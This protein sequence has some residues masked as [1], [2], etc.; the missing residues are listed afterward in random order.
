MD[1]LINLIVRFSENGDVYATSPQAPGLLYGRPSLEELHADLEEALI[2]HFERP[3]PF[4]I[5]E[6][7]EHQYDVAGHEL[8]IRIAIDDSYNE[9]AA[10]RDRIGEVITVAEQAKSVVSAVTNSA[11]EAV[12]VC[13]VPADTFGWLVAQ[14][15]PQGDALIAALTI[16]DNF[17]FTLPIAIDDA[18]RPALHPTSFEPSERLSEIMQRTPIVTMPEIIDI[19][20]EAG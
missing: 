8:V 2:F 14:L 17:L 11:G 20:I 19:D 6:H 5:L 15:Y 16:A 13:S 3:G 12:Y 10:V 7:H 1:E 18:S 9:R 4:D